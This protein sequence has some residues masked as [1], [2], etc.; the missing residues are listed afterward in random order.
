MENIWR[1]YIETEQIN[2]AGI[3]LASS[4]KRAISKVVD[5]YED[6]PLFSENIW[7]WEAKSDDSYDDN[8][9]EVL[10]VY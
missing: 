6:E 1:Y 9:P 7:V 5:F 4:K 2:A 3:V 10:P 8:N